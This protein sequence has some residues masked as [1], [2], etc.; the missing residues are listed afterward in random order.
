MKDTFVLEIKVLNHLNFPI[1]KTV[2]MASNNRIYLHGIVGLMLPVLRFIDFAT[3]ARVSRTSGAMQRI[4][5]SD[6][7]SMLASCCGQLTLCLDHV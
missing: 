1:D 4:C 3:G 7:I 2:S 5:F 6:A